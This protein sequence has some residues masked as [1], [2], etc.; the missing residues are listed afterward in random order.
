MPGTPHEV[1]LLAIREKPELF[2]EILRR[3]GGTELP[4]PIEVVDSNVRFAAR[5]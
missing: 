2:V 5:P 3:I 1:V 4:G